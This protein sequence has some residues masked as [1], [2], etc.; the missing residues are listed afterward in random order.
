MNSCVL[1]HE[2][3]G[4]ILFKNDLYRIILVNDT[5]YPGYLR[6]ILNSHVKELTDLSDQDSIKVYEALLIC[7]RVVRD[8]MLADKIN[9]ASLGN[10]VPHLHW[11]II[12]RYTNDLHF[13]NPIW[14]AVTNN[15][16]V[17]S[18]E[19]SIRSKELA[20]KLIEKLAD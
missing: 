11:H 18:G 16:Y 8:T 7:E 19:L 2:D 10:V 9:V 17:P 15:A 3:G 14:G 12:P 5:N 13:P 20:V 4:Q 6:I 1:C